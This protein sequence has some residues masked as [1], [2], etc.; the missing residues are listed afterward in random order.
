MMGSMA[1]KNDMTVDELI[2]TLRRSSLPTVLTEGGEDI[3]VFRRMEKTFEHLGLSVMAVGGREKLLQL[4]LRRGEYDH[5]KD[6][7][8]IADRDSWVF[9]KIPAEFESDELIFTWGYSIEND[10][11][12]DGRVERI[13]S[14]DEALR[15]SEE[16]NRY[17]KWYSLAISR[18]MSGFD[19]VLDIHPNEILDNE[20]NMGAACALKQ[21]EVY[22]DDLF[23]KICGNYVQMLRGKSLFSLLMRHLSYSGRPVRHNHRSI[24]EIVALAEGPL[25]KAIYRRI[26]D[27]FGNAVGEA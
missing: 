8:F 20:I 18:Y 2:A 22:P 4:F 7:A 1:S 19:Q 15:Y 25:M 10:L 13:M 9:E 23:K 26:G 16:L 11:Y 24:I 6:V 5:D 17:L 27:V 3:I 14:S 12:S 21:G